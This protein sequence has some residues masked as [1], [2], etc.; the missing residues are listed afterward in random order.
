MGAIELN[1]MNVVSCS[2]DRVN[3]ETTVAFLDKLK[4]A[5]ALA[6][7]IHVILDQSGYHK[8]VLVQGEA[9]KRNITLHYLPAYSP[10]LNPIERLWK[11]MNENVRNNVFFTSAKHFRDAISEFF[12][13]TILKIGPSLRSRIN[14]NFQTLKS[15]TFRLIGYMPRRA[16]RARL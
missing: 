5:Y 8:S 14:D 4:A 9:L 7:S 16:I 11:V 2:P 13:T 3:G 6:P 12:E 15:S 1:S 10:N